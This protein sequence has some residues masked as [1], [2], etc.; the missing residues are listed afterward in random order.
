MTT[1]ATAESLR[2]GSGHRSAGVPEKHAAKGSLSAT[3]LAAGSGTSR[4]VC[5]VTSS[6]SSLA[7][8]ESGS[9]HAARMCG[10]SA[11]RQAPR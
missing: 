6:D 4:W 10:A 11:S 5:P 1:G 2:G 9:L 3:G 8:G 7:S